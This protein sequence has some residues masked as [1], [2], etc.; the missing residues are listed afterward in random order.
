MMFY[1][2]SFLKIFCYFL[3]NLEITKELANQAGP[4]CIVRRV[5]HCT[6]FACVFRGPACKMLFSK[7]IFQT[8]IFIDFNF[9]L[10]SFHIP[11][12]I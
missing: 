3:K 6:N 12:K 1:D 4:L 11:W 8:F 9:D 5:S 10:S 7:L 2:F